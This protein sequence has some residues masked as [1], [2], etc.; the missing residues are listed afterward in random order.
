[1]PC[2]YP[3]Q[4]V[5]RPLTAWVSGG[6]LQSGILWLYSAINTALSRPDALFKSGDALAKQ[7]GLSR[8]EVYARA[9]AEYVAEYNGHDLTQRWSAMHAKE[10]SRID[11][12]LMRS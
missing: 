12:G 9:L 11:A 4:L 8:S 2:C 7:L 5:L 10:D 6:S 3:T 1:M